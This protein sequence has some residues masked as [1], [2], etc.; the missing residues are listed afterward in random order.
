MPTLSEQIEARASG[1]PFL[2]GE[3][4]EQKN[5]RNMWDSFLP[6][7][8]KKAYN[9][10][11]TGMVHQMVTGKKRFNLPTYEPGLV[12]DITASL[13][14]FFMP[15]D[16]ATV[17]IPGGIAA[18]G[19]TMGKTVQR[20]SKMLVTRGNF[21]KKTADKIAHSVA[22]RGLVS[23]AALGSYEG[24]YEAMNEGRKEIAKKGIPL[25]KFEK[26]D[27]DKILEEM[28]KKGTTAGLKGSIL[29]GS[30]GLARGA[31]FTDLYGKKYNPLKHFKDTT[32]GGW[33]NEVVAFGTVSPVLYEGRAPTF[34]DYAMAGAIIGGLNIAPK[35]VLAPFSIG[36]KAREN[37]K[38]AKEEFK[39][40]VGVM[41]PEVAKKMGFKS[42]DQFLGSSMTDDLLKLESNRLLKIDPNMKNVEHVDHLVRSIISE[43]NQEHPMK[44]LRQKM[45]KGDQINPEYEKTVRKQIDKGWK[46]NPKKSSFF[47]GR[48]LGYDD[49]NSIY[50]TKINLGRV[51]ETD[52]KGS[53]FRRYAY[54][55][56]KS[57]KKAR[58]QSSVDYGMFRLGSDMPY[59]SESLAGGT[60]M[61]VSMREPKVRYHLDK[62]NTRKW[63]MYHTHR[64]DIYDATSKI[65]KKNGTS[66]D[67]E[68]AKVRNGI[69][70]DLIDDAVSR[71]DTYGPAA[72]EGA[73]LQLEGMK[74]L[75]GAPIT[76]K[77]GK[78]R[79]PLR[80]K[81]DVKLMDAKYQP[82][83]R[84]IKIDPTTFRKRFH[85]L[86]PQQQ[87]V[88]IHLLENQRFSY[89]DY[90]IF[91]EA[92]RQNLWS[93][94]LTDPTF[95]GPLSEFFG[96]FRSNMNNLE[97]P[98]AKM[99]VNIWDVIDSGQNAMAGYYSHK[100]KSVL[101]FDSLLKKGSPW[102]NKDWHNYIKGK[103]HKYG[104]TS[105]SEDMKNKNFDKDIVDDLARA[106]G[107]GAPRRKMDKIFDK[108]TGKTTWVPRINKKEFEFHT[109][110][111]KAIEGVR[112][113]LNEMW[114][115]SERTLGRKNLAP[116]RDFYFPNKVRKE[117]F[118]FMADADKAISAQMVRSTG[119]KRLEYAVT[120][121]GL[122]S[123]II[124]QG[125]RKT[126]KLDERTREK[127]EGVML[128]YLNGIREKIQEKLKK[129]QQLTGK[130]MVK[131]GYVSLVEQV[132]RQLRKKDPDA[133]YYDVFFALRNADSNYT[134]KPMM[135]IERARGK[136]KRAFEWVDIEL[137]AKKATIAPSQMKQGMKNIQ[138]ALYE[139]DGMVVL[140]DYVNQ[141]SSRMMQAKYLGRRGER[142]N[143][144]LSRIPADKRLKGS[145]KMPDWLGGHSWEALTPT[146]EK[147]A[148]KLVSDIM[149][150]KISFNNMSTPAQV[151]TK[152]NNLEM[153]FKINAGY[154]ALLNVT[155]TFISTA[156]VAGFW[157]TVSA[158]KDSLILNPE[159]R[160]LINAVTNNLQL[161]D[162]VFG[163]NTGL[164]IAA[165][166]YR[167]ESTGVISQFVDS[168][169]GTSG[170][171]IGSF[172]NWTG[173]VSG[174]NA[175][176]KINSMVA[177]AA[178]EKLMQDMARVVS[179]KERG[180]WGKAMSKI[181]PEHR[182]AWAA[183]KLR[184]MGLNIDS[185]HKNSIL[186]FDRKAG[187]QVSTETW[188]KNNQPEVLRIMHKFA[189]DTQLKRSFV[190]DPILLQNPNTKAFLIFKRFAYR[191]PQLIYDT[192]KREWL[193]GNV[194]PVLS[195]GM[196]GFGGGQF[197]LA[198]KE[199][200]TEALTG[201]E[202]FTTRN[203]R[204]KLL[205]KGFGDVT[206]DKFLNGVSSVGAF[207]MVGEL[208]SDEEPMNA[209]NFFLKPVVLDDMMKIGRAFQ[210]FQK[211]TETHYPQGGMGAPIKA[212]IKTGS[213]IVGG[214]PQKVLKRIE[215][216]KQTKDRVRQMKRNA[217]VAAKDAI[218]G[219]NGREAS[220]IV[221]E[222]NKA[223]SGT[224]PSLRIE[225]ED[226]SISAI[227]K[228]Y[229]KKI[230][231][232]REEYEYIP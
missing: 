4:E 181:A 142:L 66:F 81:L 50:V 30:L 65:A 225:P 8:L 230:I 51:T 160:K 205:E 194:V 58:E 121:R 173:T 145:L 202:H 212:A 210:S 22:K 191:Q 168:I 139:Q 164:D 228:D 38:R 34:T 40:T 146:T 217:I 206:F 198:A 183:D 154:A 36:S 134:F 72:I 185:K 128:E 78:I 59:F 53:I 149:T 156:Q 129:G 18:K 140:S 158:A 192:L 155:Q 211:S 126:V 9:D 73:F 32:E 120:A 29:G 166:Q 231:R 108:E 124:V 94:K 5:K 10:S 123:D 77:S 45:L 86:N 85:R 13:L 157:R 116:K 107:K 132:Q 216:E 151:M 226:F 70:K 90:K 1:T 92:T 196:A 42:W 106:A 98:V 57:K 47:K 46:G 133:S 214:Y 207:G 61:L 171:R 218:I 144:M 52:P 109:L 79:H 176:N 95:S 190:R 223:W 75:G 25:S 222:Y 44:F 39:K 162:E 55:V 179:G 104:K 27:R 159:K 167:R 17:A 23:A 180:A 21:D 6:P 188:M 14:G 118:S 148:I 177:G 60:E 229:D 161:I 224:Y 227:L 130:D 213:S 83:I 186:Y 119:D 76:L 219:G 178:A 105:I 184:A 89:Q 201:E 103:K 28:V 69:G 68:I 189:V 215:T 143:S 3:N 102:Y 138:E 67:K 169:L 175:I 33:L 93:R 37:V 137:A 165:T 20:T 131:Q 101:N 197:V 232:Q 182:K 31:R 220:M 209:V 49:A 35:I 56:S 82:G 43:I 115:I 208:I 26:M 19:A 63:F 221:D 80:E 195:L 91:S 153:S 187:R 48:N 88:F 97:H 7:L 99:A 203:R 135:A 41:D 204:A 87:E 127:A 54:D 84:D 117:I 122:E 152:V 193:N 12:K 64:Q 147:G 199:W 113:N 200:I 150:N 141:W 114:G 100:F 163:G 172:V 174:F 11:I 62:E 112:S 170:D 136:H 71:P 96:A 110:R 74:G 24:V 111:K 16:I 15:I 125:E 2:P